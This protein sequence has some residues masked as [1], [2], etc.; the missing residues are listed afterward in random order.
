MTLTLFFIF[1]ILPT[2]SSRLIFY[3][4]VGLYSKPKFWIRFSLLIVASILISLISTQ[5]LPGTGK[6]LEVHDNYVIT[7]HGFSNVMVWSEYPGNPGDLVELLG[8]LE[9]IDPIPFEAVKRINYTIS[10]PKI[11]LIK[12]GKSI[13]SILWKHFSKYPNSRKLIFNQS[14]DNLPLMTSM[15]L[16][17]LGSFQIIK[18]FLKKHLNEKRERILALT[19]F[20]IYGLVFGFAFSL[21]RMILV[22]VVKREH[23]ALLCLILFPGSQLGFHFLYPYCKDLLKG[24]SSNFSKLNF[25]Q[26]FPF[27]ALLS[28]YRFNILE[29]FLYPLF[30][31]SSGIIFLTLLLIPYSGWIG[32]HFINFFSY[33]LNHRLLGIFQVVGKP[34][35]IMIILILIGYKTEKRRVTITLCLVTLILMV[36]PIRSQIVYLDVGQGDATL[37][38]S[39]LNRKVIL[40]DTGKASQVRKLDSKLK[41]YGVRRIDQVIITHDDEDHSGG[42]EYLSKHFDIKKVVYNIVD[43]KT[44]VG[45]NLN[46][47]YGDINANS[48]IMTLGMKNKSFLFTGDAGRRQEMDLIRSYPGLQIDFLKLGHHGSKTSTDPE[49]IKWIKPKYAIASSNPKIYGHP[50]IEVKKNLHKSRV[51]LLQTSEEGDIRVVFTILFDFI[52]TQARGF[53]II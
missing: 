26:L 19:Y 40:I 9:S 49:F 1:T 31:L 13:K 35:I 5:A 48:L 38:Q 2:S 7:R 22:R 52:H 4:L 8:K 14:I 46:K 45:L 21:I 29:M 28:S 42:L 51:K 33:V 25:R 43:V 23:S 47:N 37:I 20:V 32:N 36:F 27:L 30:K 17:I 18:H 6:V 3:F 24:L 50:H 53:A 44:L 39:A 15:S 34:S 16:Q 11:K 10:N 41:S 12:E